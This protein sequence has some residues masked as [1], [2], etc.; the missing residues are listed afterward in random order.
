M[1]NPMYHFLGIGGIGMSA[2]VHILLEKGE[3]VSGSDLKNT[4]HLKKLGVQITQKLPPQA[5]V[6]YSTAIKSDHP[7]IISAKKHNLPL[8][9]R[10]ALL[11]SLLEGKQA[12]LVT[13]THGK[14]ST[15]ALLSWTLHAAGLKPTYAVG[16]ILR[17]F[18]KNGGFGL[19]PYFVAE[20]DE[21]DGSFLNYSGDGAIIT[22]IEKEHLDYWKS[23]KKILEGFQKFIS[24]IKD[25]QLL[26]YCSDD[27]LLKELQPPGISYGKKGALRLVSYKQEGMKMV[28]T[29]TFKG[30]KYEEIELPLL[31]KENVLNALAVFG[32][33]LQLGIPEKKIRKAFST[34]KGVKRRL[35]KVGEVNRITLYDDYAHH[36]TEIRSILLA[37]RKAYP[38]RR[39][40]ILFQPHRYTRTKTLDF[41][42]AFE[43][44]DLA[45]ITDIYSAGEKPILG[46]NGQ[47][48]CKK[49]K[50]D[51]ALFLSKDKLLTLLP[52]MLVPGD[53][54]VTAGAG[55]ITEIGPQLLRQ[56]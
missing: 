37:L 53:V 39:L 5:K 50:G 6:V 13:G 34:F 42:E 10:S 14:T 41:S 16:G 55:D 29:A 8:I 26:F 18:N 33:A 54:L 12:L 25:L 30:V 36:P 43:A 31:G 52:K 51:N 15:T 9:H 23:E 45:I 21:S 19:G 7:G 35:E 47:S 56:L 28:F 11:K 44:A 46:V 27:P 49:L 20:A 1:K 32:M 38:N 3:K 2:L 4:S 17:N 24:Q 48:F 40:M 22:N